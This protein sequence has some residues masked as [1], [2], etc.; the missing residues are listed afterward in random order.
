MLVYEGG[1]VEWEDREG[2]GIQ[3]RPCSLLLPLT[4]LLLPPPFPSLTSPSSPTPSKSSIP[5]RSAVEE[6]PACPSVCEEEG[7][8]LHIGVRERVQGQ[9]AL[10]SEKVI[11][12]SRRSFP[13][14][15]SN[16]DPFF[17]REKV[18]LNER[19]A[20]ESARVVLDLFDFE[21]L[22]PGLDREWLED[23][24]RLCRSSLSFP[25]TS[26]FLT[27]VIT[28]SELKFYRFDLRMTCVG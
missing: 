24:R 11:E 4:F 28:A 22:E 20:T 8:V 10:L 18:P 1:H 15:A 25:S 17:E 3:R 26:S 19:T 27:T 23:R 13:L 16:H 12:P 5:S 14:R 9:P 2:G 7:S 21:N 6:R